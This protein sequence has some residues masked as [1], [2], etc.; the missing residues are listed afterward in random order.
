M[1]VY[2]VNSIRAR[3]PHCPSWGTWGCRHRE[4]LA[5]HVVGPGGAGV[6]AACAGTNGTVSI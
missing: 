1:H 4:F 6:H 3:L 5:I 2:T